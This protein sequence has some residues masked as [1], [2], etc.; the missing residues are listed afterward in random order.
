MAGDTRG[1]EAGWLL[2]I[3]QLP[4]QPAYLRVKIWRRLQGLG[5][6]AIKNSVYVL[7]AGDEPLEDFQWVLRE[8]EEGGGEASICEARFVEGLSD[9]EI[10]D[11]FHA[12]RNADYEQI[13]AEARDLLAALR[14]ADRAGEAAA[15]IRRLRRRLT[16]AAAIDYFEAPARRT[17]EEALAAAEAGLVSGAEGDE[18]TLRQP[19]RPDLSR[20]RGCTWVTRREVHIDRMAS[21]WLIRRFIDPQAR[22]LFV[23]ARGYRPGPGELRFDMFEAE[24]THEGDRCTFEVLIERARLADPALRQIAEIVHDIDFKDAKYDRPEAPGI[25]QLVAGIVAAHAADEDRIER[26]CTVFDDLLAYFRRRRRQGPAAGV[27]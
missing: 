10:R 4:P 25:G 27:P 16:Q 5:A 9:A 15:Q 22:F 3:H 14:T 17:A 23:P 20:V 12:A 6:V 24:F 8:I 2:L 21:A 26:A 1:A 13:A 18:A 11:L 19:P 7:P